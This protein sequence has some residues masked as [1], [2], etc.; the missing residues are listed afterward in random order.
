MIVIIPIGGI[1]KRFKDN[2]YK[3]PKSL[4]NVLG[5][6]I[7]FY[8]L[9]CI[10]IE[11]INFI[12]IIY[13]K[14]YENYRFEDLLKK[15]YSNYN[16]KF[17]LLNSETEGAAHTINIGL[18]KLDIPDCPVLCLDSDCFYNIDIIKLWNGSN[19]I[20]VFNDNSNKEIYSYIKHDN[21]K[22]IDIKEKEKISQLACSGA[23]GFSSYKEL[24]QYTNYILDNK[25]KYKNEY[26][27]SNIIK[28]MIENSIVFDYKI[29]NKKDWICLGTPIQVRLFCNNYPK[30][31]I[32]N[33]EKIKCKRYC[34]D[35]DNTLVT[36]PINGDYTTVKPIQKNINF[37]KYLKNFGHTIIIYT[38]RRMNTH[39][40]NVGKLLI[41]IGKITF[42]TLE[43]FNIPC[44]EIYFGKPY[45][46]IYIDDL[47]L[48]CYDDLEKN[49]G[50]Y[51]ET[52]KP[53]DFNNLNDSIIEI[54]TKES[55][56]LSGEIYYY[57]NIP[58]ELK[59]LFP[60]LIDYDLNNKWYKIEKINCL[61]ATSLY[62]S[63]LLTNNNLINIMNSIA[64]IQ[65]SIL[66]DNNNINIYDNYC[67][68]L[69]KRYNE[70]D[71]SKFE[72]HD[73]IYKKIYNELLI[74]EQEDKGIKKVIH[75]D[76]VLTNILIN[77]YDKIKFIDMR[78][79]VGNFLTIH[80]DWLYDWA[81]LFQSLVGYDKILQNK[82]INN[83]Y[84]NKMINI[85]INFFIEK[86]SKEDFNNL[87]IITKSLLFS[88]I[89]LHNN[90]KCYKYFNLINN[91][92]MYK[93]N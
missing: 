76:P 22:I 20:F 55:D 26:Y 65:N 36:F 31:N 12:Y 27:T 72:F 79:K 43:K 69:K 90:D 57:N 83:N 60:I 88:L 85:F 93:K 47:A 77:Q 5:H 9:D 21:N 68:K 40:G 92:D 75:G 25:I 10:N 23:Y 84:E 49:L 17:L 59:D 37:A 44:D 54:Y 66:N 3:N 58:K 33:N 41:D 89:P 24:L 80:G 28:Q 46:D 15:K 70:Y 39:N 87:I 32:N 81:K 62:L 34:F 16:F 4:I 1:G 7:L 61:T 53:R 13:N 38:A 56:D 50:F 35:L 8:L 29:I 78:G 52:I 19:K 67:M 64:R 73:I 45:A 48:N 30:I 82:D 71:Y 51:T 42:E 2:G 63:E 11:L 18:N 86:Y 91:L 6:P 14:E 74:Y